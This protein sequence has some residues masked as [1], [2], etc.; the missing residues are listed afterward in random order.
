MDYVDKTSDY[1]NFGGVKL[2][3]D[4]AVKYILIKRKESK[5]LG[6]NA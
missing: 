6:I 5:S 4:I 3:L 1:Q 2:I